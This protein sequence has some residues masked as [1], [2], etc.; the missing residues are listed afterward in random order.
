M[1]PSWFQALAARLPTRR[2]TLIRWI[3]IALAI[4]IGVIL[5]MWLW[6]LLPGEVWFAAGLSALGLLALW[7]VVKGIPWYRQRRFLRAQPGDLTPGDATEEAEPRR[8]ME[9]A[10]VAAKDVLRH[11]PLLEGG[12]DP[13]YRV[14]WFL[15][16]GDA[17]SNQAGLLRAA[18]GTSPFPASPRDA[19]A[20]GQL[21]QWWFYKEAIA[22]ETSP[23]FVCDVSDRASRGL[24]YQALQLLSQHR[25]RLPL[26]G[27]LV[28]V[29]ATA[30]GAEKSGDELREHGLRLRRV[31]DEAMKYLQLQLPVYIIVTRCDDLS[32]FAEFL[33]GLPKEARGQVLGY[34]HDMGL[35]QEGPPQAL[36]E[37]VFEDMRLRLH[38][39]RLGLLKNEGNPTRRRG[40]FEFV[41]AFAGLKPG[42]ALLFKLVFEENPFQRTPQWRGLYFAG[43]GKHPAFVDDFFTR[44]L[45]ADQP[46]ATRTT[47]SR[48]TR[49]L[50]IMAGLALAGGVSWYA[51]SAITASHRQD[52]SLLEQARA[53]CAGVTQDMP[54]GSLVTRFRQCAEQIAS[55][56]SESVERGLTFGINRS[57]QHLSQ[58]KQR[59]VSDYQERVIGPYDRQLGTDRSPIS[60]SHYLAQVQRLA[61]VHR[62][63]EGPRDCRLEKVQVIF[64]PETS[65]FF[66]SEAT[67]KTASGY[68]ALYQTYLSY[69]RWAGTETLTAERE[70]QRQRLG[71]SL[72]V[73]PL[74]PELLAAWA[75]PRFPGYTLATFWMPSV[76]PGRDA[77]AVQAAYTRKVNDEVLSPFAAEFQQVFP[78]GQGAL[79]AFRSAYH[80][81]YFAQWQG[82]LSGFHKGAQ[83]WDGEFEGLVQRMVAEDNPYALL[84][85]A[86]RTHVLDFKTDGKPPWVS[87]LAYTLD[88][89]WP[90]AQSLFAQLMYSL[91][92][93]HSGQESYALA[94][95]IFASKGASTAASAQD[96]WHLWH[97]LEK[98]RPE[99]SAA[100]KVAD[101]EAWFVVRGPVRLWLLLTAYR[102]GD[103]LQSQWQAK[104]QTPLNSLP[105]KEHDAFLF[106]EKDTI[107]NF[108]DAWLSPFLTERERQ[109]AKILGVSLPITAEALEFF[110]QN[111]GRKVSK[112]V[113]P[114]NAGVIRFTRPSRVGSVDE[115][116]EGTQFELDCTSSRVANSR[117][118]SR[119]TVFW[120]PDTC[121]DVRVKISIP[122]PP[123]P[124]APPVPQG[125]TGIAATALGPVTPPRP[126]ML[127]KTYPGANGFVDFVNGFK[128]GSKSFGLNDFKAS[129][130]P[131][132]WQEVSARLSALGATRAQVFI[133]VDLSE[134]MKEFL[135][136]PR[137]F[138]VPPQVV[139]TSSQFNYP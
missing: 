63:L 91:Q 27:I 59:F 62:C 118:D 105:P 39:I 125:D 57:G 138:T 12:K 69:L 77:L 47:Q 60:F 73:Q 127:T 86:V 26:N 36:I 6:P 89:D 43:T 8:A 139:K 107:G 80:A 19:T 75:A 112:A 1:S 128:S 15:V 23:R 83:L 133:T 98:P 129:Y 136:G 132:Q 99:D 72:K 92:K 45:P 52:R 134:Q 18:S 88:K 40:V 51:T 79:K 2:G 100:M 3:I 37:K 119:V 117:T 111:Q 65:G 66:F 64:T 42:L 11:S 78:E 25:P 21:W 108:L 116:T 61:L 87:A 32:G 94:S 95:D 48:V 93:D 74:A 31:L 76:Q 20:E 34:R 5:V 7:A 114:F 131:F 85:K 49:W 44:F 56:E 70:N 97:L 53:A 28:C 50:T 9:R 81:Q 67:A 122:D 126:L 41:E 113:E 82:L 13:L 24:W 90:R 55:L 10:L 84:W 115:G 106:G 54:R 109:P 120:S 58:L 35:S 46:L 14:P 124:P 130:S 96:F 22:L 68:D 123:P 110:H 29:P 137:P 135:K 4:L 101:Q 104:V 103:Y 121:V 71:H 38:T 102:V 33:E 16:L 17:T 30:L